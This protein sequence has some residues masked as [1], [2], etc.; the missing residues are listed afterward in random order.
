[1]RCFFVVSLSLAYLLS[2]VGASSAQ[3]TL[4]VTP[5]NQTGEIL[6]YG[7][8]L[9]TG[10]QLTFDIAVRS[11][12]TPIFGIGA[13]AVGYPSS[14]LSFLSGAVTL[15]VL[16]EIC[17]DVQGCF[18]GLEAT[19]SQMLP[20]EGQFNEDEVQFLNHLKITGTTATGADEFGLDG[21]RGSAQAS[22][23]FEVTGGPGLFLQDETIAIGSFYEYGD[24]V[25]LEGGV[26]GT[27]ETIWVVPEPG[28]ALLMGL[29]LLGLATRRPR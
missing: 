21:E 1:M 13:S 22:L 6:D 2:F 5:T 20:R 9:S 29:G 27:V 17:L 28:T 25:V 23:L 8:P 15:H 14:G 26:S 7:A 3:V 12:G 19:P 16:S 24:V 4:Y 10:D 11:D 18:G